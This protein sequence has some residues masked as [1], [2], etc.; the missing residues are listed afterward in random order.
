MI[1]T[2][3]ASMFGDR[4]ATSID[5]LHPRDPA[6]VKM[7][8]LG[9]NAKSGVRVDGETVL[10][11]A[12][13]LRGV[14]II[15]NALMKVRP[16]IFK[17][18][19]QGGEDD[20]ERDRSHSSWKFVTKRAHPLISAGFFRK[21]LTSW[22]ILRGNGLAYVHRDGAGRIL[23]GLPLLP[24]RSGMAIFRRGTQL[25]GE[26]DVQEDDEIR[27]WTIVGGAV[28]RLLPENV[29]HI[30]GLSNNGFWGYDIVDVLCE[31]FGSA[32]ATRD[33]GSQFFGQGAMPGGIVFAPAG[34]KE[35][36]QKAFAEKVRTAS[37]GLGKAHRLMILED[38]AKYEQISID[39]EKAQLLGTRQ[40][41][42]G[43]LAAAVRIQ[44]HKIGDT[45][46][47][48]YNSLE[49][50]NQE[51]LDDDLDPWLQVWEDELEHK[52]LTEREKDTETHL[53]EFNRKAL[54]RVNL[55]ARTQRHQ[56]ERQN[57]MKTA[58]QILRQENE[59]PIGAVGDTYMVPA[60]MTV[61][62]KDGLP[63]IRGQ[64]APEPRGRDPKPDDNA[65]IH[66]AYQ[67]LAMHAV[68]R[69]AKRATAEAARQAK[70][71]GAAY[72]SFLDELTAWTH[73]PASVAPLL[74]STCEVIH[75][76]LAAF[77]EPPYLANEL[78]AN[79]TAAA[80]AIQAEA[81]AVAGKQLE[82]HE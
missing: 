2:A 52:C 59:P 34:L 47:A 35:A 20:K 28:R 29:I 11:L 62:D 42:L 3:L 21:T 15:G 57:G 4:A 6:L 54:V 10:S 19:A 65:S 68:E 66:A 49:Q 18:L 55:Q 27:Y 36:Q 5:P 78:H 77:A 67:E 37:Q 12:P 22:A 75:Q 79:V 7:F 71:G 46:R 44:P 63:I 17:R 13:V 69:L 72:L 39:P 31:T 58:N 51:H 23:H 33:F 61:L 41:S 60:N 56:F 81:I 38:T 9:G 48:S 16:H 73:Q 8:G 53:V 74:E 45:S 14:D 43:E 24:D 25:I 1:A 64:A 30:K 50:S 80:A 40:F 76:R 70:Q 82:I 26:A 32:I